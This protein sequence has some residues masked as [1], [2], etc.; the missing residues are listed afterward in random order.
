MERPEPVF[1]LGILRYHTRDPED[2]VE[3]MQPVFYNWTDH[4]QT[5]AEYCADV[6][7]STRNIA[8]TWDVERVILYTSRL[9]Y[10]CRLGE[11][12]VTAEV[13]EAYDRI[14]VSRRA[15]FIF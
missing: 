13:K 6:L 7:A 4:W 10:I 2:V 14:Y 9:D 11:I 8:A 3:E 1:M 5:P 12:D 15:E